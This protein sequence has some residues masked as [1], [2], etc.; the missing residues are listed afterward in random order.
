MTSRRASDGI[1]RCPRQIGRRLLLA[2]S[3]AGSALLALPR[4]ALAAEGVPDTLAAPARPGERAGE[5]GFPIGYLGVVWTGGGDCSVRFQT[6]NGW[7]DWRPVPHADTPDPDSAVSLVPGGGAQGYEVRPPAGAADVRIVAINTTDGPRH[8]AA[9]P[10]AIGLALAESARQGTFRYLARAG[11][12]ADESLRLR[13]NGAELL[14]SQYFPVQAFTV[15]HT[16][17]SNHDPDPAATV[18]AI[19]YFHT[20][21]RDFGDVGYHLLIDEGGTVYEGRWSGAD[22]FPVFGGA[23]ESGGPPL[24]NNA[25]HVGGFNAG[26][27]GIA[28]IGDLTGTGPTPA[29]RNSLVEVL[30]GLTSVTGVDPLAQVDYVNP[31]GGDTRRVPAIAGHRDWKA[32]ACPGGAFY[33]DLHTLRGDVAA[34]LGR[35]PVGA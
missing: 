21:T 13:P 6:A 18:R 20:I 12:G 10:P 28:L 35:P 26:N 29:A 5:P 31:I 22:P 34:R 24:M 1:T 25:A 2:A 17:T 32:T 27:V 16:V 19:A 8:R 15:H 7:S 11:W 33:P 30:A 9:A 3:L 4:P 23:S 14:P